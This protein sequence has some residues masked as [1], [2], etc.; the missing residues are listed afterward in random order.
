MMKL[1]TFEI[2]VTKVNGLGVSGEHD[3]FVVAT[4]MATALAIF[5]KEFKSDEVVIQSTHQSPCKVL[6]EEEI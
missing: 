5:N 6:V 1:F 2:K 4:D 3:V